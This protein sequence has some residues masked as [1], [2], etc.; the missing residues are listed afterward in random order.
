MYEAPTYS[1]VGLASNMKVK[2]HKYYSLKKIEQ[3]SPKVGTKKPPCG[4]EKC[5]ICN[6]L[7][8]VPD[9][10]YLEFL[11]RRKIKAPLPALP[12]IKPIKRSQ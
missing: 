5:R 8:P 11:S 4:N 2:S 12:F 9:K 10:K 1:R 7:K 3:A 6:N